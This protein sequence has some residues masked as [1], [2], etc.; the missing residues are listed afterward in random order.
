MNQK[1]LSIIYKIVNKNNR[2]HIKSN[3]LALL[4]GLCILQ[5]EQRALAQNNDE[6]VPEYFVELQQFI[7]DIQ[8]ELRYFGEDNFLGQI[9]D[10]YHAEKGRMCRVN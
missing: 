9:V 1:R 8:L 6:S 3:V 7:L 2:L 10:G 5:V 4:L